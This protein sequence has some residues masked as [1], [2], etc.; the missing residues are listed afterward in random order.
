MNG[1][2]IFFLLNLV[3][4]ENVIHSMNVPLSLHNLERT[5][6]HLTKFLPTGKPTPESDVTPK[7]NQ[8]EQSLK[9]LQSYFTELD[10]LLTNVYS[11]PLEKA[12]FDSSRNPVNDIAKNAFYQ[13]GSI[14]NLFGE[15]K[16]IS[17]NIEIILT[18]ISDDFRKT[19]FTLDQK[20]KFIAILMNQDTKTLKNIEQKSQ[21]MFSK[22]PMSPIKIAI[23]Q[24][25]TFIR[26]ILQYVNL[27]F[28][29][30]KEL[31]ED[32]QKLVSDDIKTIKSFQNEIQ[33]IYNQ[34]LNF[35]QHIKKS[36]LPQPELDMAINNFRKINIIHFFE[37]A[38]FIDA[39]SVY[40]PFIKD[41]NLRTT[42]LQALADIVMGKNFSEN[43][44]KEV[45]AT[46]KI[47]LPEDIMIKI[48]SIIQNFK[49]LESNLEPKM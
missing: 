28:P 44:E 19:P 42:L 33:E 3:C 47:S 11:L 25:I 10:T 45:I 29:R 49:N 39:I 4:I 48:K 32:N 14:K 46:T 38:C 40:I 15:L 7:F 37:L 36:P 35:F 22:L 20:K 26:C 34:S 24:S 43:L 9:D 8:L 16:K 27:T 23:E 41:V 17:Q 6:T 13:F 31:I 12:E 5:L 21:A 1:K 2:N 30:I 18:K